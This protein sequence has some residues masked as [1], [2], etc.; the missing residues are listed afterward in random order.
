VNVISVLSVGNII[1]G[2]KIF[3]FSNFNIRYI[4]I[5]NEINQ[6]HFFIYFVP[7]KFILFQITGFLARICRNGF[8]KQLKLETETKKLYFN[9]SVLFLSLTLFKS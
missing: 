4:K 8:N 1:Y 6:I 5:L 9:I 7:I 3:R 2:E